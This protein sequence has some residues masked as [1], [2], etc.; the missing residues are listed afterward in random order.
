[1]SLAAARLVNKLIGDK[2]MGRHV[3]LVSAHIC[4]R[5]GWCVCTNWPWKH[6][7]SSPPSQQDSQAGTQRSRTDLGVLENSRSIENIPLSLFL[8]WRWPLLVSTCLWFFLF[9]MT[10]GRYHFCAHNKLGW[11]PEEMY[12]MPTKYINKTCDNH[13]LIMLAICYLPGN[14]YEFV[15][16]DV[17][18]Y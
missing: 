13:A 17:E 16:V 4:P 11:Y 6:C 5:R 1:M 9:L 8:S 2:S 12:K 10:F 3:H 15:A 18:L 7:V 14:I